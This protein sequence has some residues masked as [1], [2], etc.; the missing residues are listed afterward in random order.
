[1]GYELA[2]NR[3]KRWGFVSLAYAIIAMV[4]TWPL[5]AHLSTH[6]P[7]GTDSLLHYWNGWWSWTAWQSG[8]SPYTTSHLFYPAGVSLVYHNFAWL[9]ILLWGIIRPFSGNIAAYN[10]TFLL[11]L[12]LCGLS[13]FWLIA[14]LTKN[15][16]AAFLGGLIYLA[17]PHRLTH[18]SH[19]NMMSTWAIPLFLLFLYKVVENKRWQDG[20]WAG[21]MLALVGYMRWQLLIPASLMGGLFLVLTLYNKKISWTRLKPL[22]LA[23]AVAIIV[24]LPPILLLASEWQGNPTE[25]VLASENLSMQTDALAYGVPPGA[26]FLLG[27]VTQPLYEHFYADRGSRNS[28]SPYIGYI[29]LLLIAIG[30]WQNGRFALPWLGMALMLIL[31]ALGPTLRI[32]GQQFTAVPMP[33]NWIDAIIP[34]RLLREPDRFNMFLALPV[35]VLATL[36]I[37]TLL[38]WAK[39]RHIQPYLLLAAVGGAIFLEYLVTPLGL[40]TVSVSPFYSQLA[41]SAAN[42]AVLN[43]PVDPFQ[44]KP[45]MFAQTISQRPILQ[46]H[47]SRYPPDAFAY[48]ETQ[49]WLQEMLKFNDI[50]PKQTNISDQLSQ[51]AADGIGHLIVH[52]TAVANPE[53]WKQYLAIPP[54]FED[55]TIIAY[56]TA[57]A[58]DKNLAFM[59]EPA[60]DLGIV[61]L[62]R[63]PTCLQPGDPIAVE[64]AW[65]NSE[66]LTNDVETSLTLVSEQGQTVAEQTYKLAVSAWQANTVRWEYTHLSLPPSVALGPYELWLTLYDPNTNSQRHE[67][68]RL[69]TL[70]VATMCPVAL[71]RQTT[72]VFAKFGDAIE[73]QGYQL[74]EDETTLTLTLH[75]Q[76]RRRLDVDYK[77]FIHIFD[78]AT[79]IPAAQDDA[80]PRR[81]RYPTSYWQPLEQ[82]DDAIPIDISSLS[83]GTYGV[84]IGIY[85]P[86][87][88]ERL[89]VWDSQQGTIEDSRLVLGTQVVLER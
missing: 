1:M 11:N 33:Y 19:P 62:G 76:T 72:A 64:L 44:S 56:E 17:W 22:F 85:H 80:M 59:H 6:L 28:F 18:P 43:I 42:T 2:V 63:L 3:Y 75:W 54:A 84:A 51:L 55:D 34:I 67:P 47:V 74:E 78:P 53:N 35:A 41:Q 87:S 39:Q 8:Q 69:H 50:P 65:G 79:G 88:G 37:R 5:T 40:Q 13:A 29:V 10:L 58:P 61:R 57:S 25:V 36:G 12:V 16:R 27:G 73:L 48:L 15:D 70:E 66:S 9:H 38:A 21:L 68:I 7:V 4:V 20:V 24:L 82:I 14:T 77:V 32:N 60:P 46:G 86:Q 89:T 83:N 31:L 26:H 81:W 45:Y 52:K 71:P 30:L 49:P 23:G